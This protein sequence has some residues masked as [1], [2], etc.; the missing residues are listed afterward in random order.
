MEEDYEKMLEDAREDLPEEVFESARFTIPEADT[1]KSGNKTVINNF[2]DI[3]DNLGRDKKHLTKYLLK[4]LGTAGHRE[5]KELILQGKFRRGKINGKIED[6]CEEYVICDECSRPDT[7]LVKEK[8]V[9]IL[10][11]EAC[12]ARKSV[13]E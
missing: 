5:G 2:G 3:A 1:Q 9:T 7:R 8:G 11:C 12:G 10:K 13:E 6:Y 4:E